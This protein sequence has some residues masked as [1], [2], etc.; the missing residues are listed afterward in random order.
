[1]VETN[2]EAQEII[3]AAY[4]TYDKEGNDYEFKYDKYRALDA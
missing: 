1:V 2:E 4:K 3:D